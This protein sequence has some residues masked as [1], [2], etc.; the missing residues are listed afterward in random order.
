M[1]VKE[2]LQSRQATVYSIF[3]ASPSDVVGERQ[4]IPEVIYYWNA[5]NSRRYGVMLEPILWETHVSPEMGDRPQSIINKQLVENSDI[6]I[7]IFWTRLGTHTGSAESGTVE[8]IEEFLKAGKP[9]LLYFSSAPV[10]PGSV[11]DEQYKKL[12]DVKKK[13]RGE[14][15]VA[16]YKSIVELREQLQGHITLT[17]DSLQTK[18]RYGKLKVSV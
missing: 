11:D 15:I 3:I 2:V 9:V 1:L 12:R 4:A 17:I 6:L 18:V 10:V 14:G 7:G 8:E 5:V 16:D 13:R